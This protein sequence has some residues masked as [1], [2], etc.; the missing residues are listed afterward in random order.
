MSILRSGIIQQHKPAAH[1]QASKH[2]YEQAV[3][4]VINTHMTQTNSHLE[5]AA[6]MLVQTVII[7]C[8]T[9]GHTCTQLDACTVM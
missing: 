7:T 1:L 3:L 4:G 2:L 6:T 8:E 5:K 9:G